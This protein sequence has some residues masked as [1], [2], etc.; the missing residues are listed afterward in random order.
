MRANDILR[1]FESKELM[2]HG[3]SSKF[4]KNILDK[5]LVFD[6][7][8]RVWGN[9]NPSSSSNDLESF[10]GTYLTLNFMTA[11]SAAGNAYR[12]FGGNRL[13]VVANIETRTP[14]VVADEDDIKNR[15]SIISKDGRL[16]D[17]DYV[18]IQLLQYPKEIDYGK[19][20][21][22]FKKRAIKSRFKYPKKLDLVFPLFKELIFA[23]ILWELSF[24]DPNDVMSSTAYELK[25]LRKQFDFKNARKNYRILFDKF[26]KK[27]NFMASPSPNNRF[28]HSVRNT[29][30]IGFRGKNRI[31]FIA[32]C[33]EN[34]DYVWTE[35]YN[36]NNKAKKMLEDDLKKSL[37]GRA[38]IH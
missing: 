29:E 20:W 33:S 35:R 27:V 18:K 19:A 32:E 6:D 12:K 1:L 26:I 16:T 34:D 7:K 11:Y 15:L 24:T 3:T 5:G 8:S 23:K 36:K 9:A 37:S 2:Y 38:V 30:P 17:G 31:V 4:L 13:M 28:L 22:L 10:P 25:E 14:Q 21:D